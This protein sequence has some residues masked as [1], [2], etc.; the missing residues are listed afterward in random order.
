MT[1]KVAVA[2]VV[3]GEGGAD[4]RR[5]RQ[6]IRFSELLDT[7]IRQDLGK[8]EVGPDVDVLLVVGIQPS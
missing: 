1:K 2:V 3:V 7:S 8:I 6:W 5:G 4:D